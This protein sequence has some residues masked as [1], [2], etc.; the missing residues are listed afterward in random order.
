[1]RCSMAPTYECVEV[2]VFACLEIRDDFELNDWLTNGFRKPAR[3]LI[4]EK[5]KTIKNYD[6][7]EIKRLK[8]LLAAD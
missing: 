6:N 8:N 7:I 1:M 4:Y 2:L 5:K 3:L